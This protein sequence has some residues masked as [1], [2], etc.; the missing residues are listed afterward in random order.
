[1]PRT[2]S[3]AL[4]IGRVDGQPNRVHPRPDAPASLQQIIC[5]LVVSVPPSHFRDGD[6]DLIEMY[7]AA[8]AL[9]RQ[10][11][12][13]LEENGPVIDGRVSPWVTTLEKAHR[14]A[15]ALAGKLRLCP[16]SRL[17]SKTVAR[18]VGPSPSYYDV[19]RLEKSDGDGR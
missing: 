1:M 12:T 5:D 4:E 11:Y 8:I 2:S 6:R 14:S 19:M 10:S 3:A 15:V 18:Q 17:D 13:E 16:Q 9:S 7:A